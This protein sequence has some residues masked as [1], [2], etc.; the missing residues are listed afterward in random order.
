MIHRSLRIDQE[1]LKD[2]LSYDF[3]ER[4]SSHAITDQCISLRSYF[5]QAEAYVTG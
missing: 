5:R 1:H 3:L 4:S 2:S